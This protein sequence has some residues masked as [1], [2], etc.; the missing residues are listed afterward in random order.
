MD[1]AQ[2]NLSRIKTRL[3]TLEMTL[4]KRI[5]NLLNVLPLDDQGQHPVSP[6]PSMNSTFGEQ[7][8]FMSTP[9]NA[10]T[11]IRRAMR[12]STNYSTL[13]EPS[14]GSS[15]SLAARRSRDAM[16]KPF[17]IM[18]DLRKL[19]ETYRSYDT[20]AE[21]MVDMLEAE[22]EPYQKAY[23]KRE[24]Y[25]N[26]VMDMVENV[27]NRIW[28]LCSVQ[29]SP[30]PGQNSDEL[31]RWSKHNNG[32]VPMP[33]FVPPP[34]H[35]E[36]DCFS[37]T[38]SRTSSSQSQD[39]IVVAIS[40]EEDAVKN[41]TKELT[42]IPKPIKERWEVRQVA[43]IV[44]NTATITN[45]VA[46]QPSIVGLTSQQ[47][48]PPSTDSG[49]GHSSKQ[50]E[51]QKNS[52]GSTPGSDR[53]NVDDLASSEQDNRT[54]D[55]GGGGPNPNGGGGGGPND[56]D[57][58][59][60]D[61]DGDQDEDSDESLDPEAEDDNDEEASPPLTPEVKLAR[62]KVKSCK[63]EIDMMLSRL[64]SITPTK[65]MKPQVVAVIKL[66]LADVKECANRELQEL[67][68]RLC[69][70]DPWHLKSHAVNAKKF[71]KDAKAR[72][73]D[74]EVKIVEVNSQEVAVDQSQAAAR[75]PS[76]VNTS[77]LP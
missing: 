30:L 15:L 67:C 20:M 18:D 36:D 61:E 10:S 23:R 38:P 70:L 52:G 22:S 51:G 63:E 41:L 42:R 47:Q 68:D 74:L 3:A 9:A 17:F 12:S 64:K 13:S 21:E 34:D 25:N 33:G 76:S 19:V 49:S 39:S 75:D 40:E 55:G 50:A 7:P 77:H 4:K 11:V 26:V 54:G 71:K 65:V 1:E 43:N 66:Q 37:R 72:I 69:E 6:S 28:E 31:A 16:Q 14:E 8:S 73:M 45:T 46:T 59:P 53:Q 2:K 44:A 48:P 5:H 60:H 27:E 29:Q 62:L 57:D 32:V 35:A 24:H 58:D 56:D